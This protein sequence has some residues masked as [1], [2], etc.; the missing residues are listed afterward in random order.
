MTIRASASRSPADFLERAG[1]WLRARED[2]HN[3]LLGLVGSRAEADAWP[4]GEC[5]GVVEADGETIGC[6]VRT[7]PHKVLL[8]DLPAGAAPAVAELL[9]GLYE[10][11]PA[12]FGPREPAVALGEEWTRIRGGSARVGMPQGLYRIDAVEPPKGVPGRMRHPTREEVELVVS[13]GEGFGRDTGI[14]F[15][16]GSEPI[17]RWIAS[18]VLHVWDVDGRPVSVAVAHGRTARGIRVGY[19][20]TPPEERG[21][22]YAS[23]LV[24]VLSQSMLDTGFDFCVL[25]TDLTN[26]TSNAIYQR[27]GYRLIS[28]LT[29]VDLIPPDGL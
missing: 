14:P 28:E 22:G 7:P 11:I 5:F 19:V 3:L 13:W 2:H 15:P 1:P 4:A 16:P 26:P 29:D 10:V 12:I 18:G 20:Y 27:L 21:H 25:Y 24:A 8:T 23:A 9:S 17:L 6:V